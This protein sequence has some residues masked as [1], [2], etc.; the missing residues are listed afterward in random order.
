LIKV[1]FVAKVLGNANGMGQIQ[2]P[3]PDQSN[4]TTTKQQQESE[5]DAVKP[6]GRE[7]TKVKV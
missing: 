1:A 4:N 2:H 6:P 3:V 7:R 5:F